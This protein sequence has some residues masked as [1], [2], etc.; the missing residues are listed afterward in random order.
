M[1]AEVINTRNQRK[2]IPILREGD[3]LK[4]APS[5]LLGKVYVDL[6]GAPYAEH[7]YQDLLTTV[8][9]A[10]SVAPPVGQKKVVNHATSKGSPP[11]IQDGG[12]GFAP[13]VITGV[14]IDEIGQPRND[15]TP[16]SALYRVP[17]RLSRR[18]P[19]E[20]VDLFI[21]AWDHPPRFSTMHRPGTASI[22]GD[23]I[24]L[25]RTTIEEVEKYHRET[26]VLA[27]QV[28]NQKYAALLEE[29]LVQE[30][31][32]EAQAAEHKRQMEDVAKRISFN[33]G[34]FNNQ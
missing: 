31:I 2:F 15:G 20:W 18:P 26:L 12:E 24:S 32:R 27:T 22:A 13:I 21:A 29:R 23:T 9:G 10:R 11:T 14:I 28:A 33:D 7:H 6:S 19:R 5:W 4:A 8:L 34:D 25:S 3:W 16:G 17:F 30:Q 1:T